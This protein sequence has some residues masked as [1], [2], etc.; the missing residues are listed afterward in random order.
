MKSIVRMVSAVVMSI[1]LSVVL[2]SCGGDSGTNSGG[3]GG[4][5]GMFTL[6][7]IPSKYNGMYAFVFALNL[8]DS[9][10]EYFIYGYKNLDFDNAVYTLVRISNGKVSVPMW[11][12]DFNV[13]LSTPNG[14]GIKRYS[15][16]DALFVTVAFTGSEKIDKTPDYAKIGV[17]YASVKFSKGSATKSWNDGVPVEMP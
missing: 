14:S 8:N 16:N 13:L 7:N 6:T 2:T 9:D 4:S 15:G 3:G 10:S 5:G 17:G 11:K 12:L 1:I